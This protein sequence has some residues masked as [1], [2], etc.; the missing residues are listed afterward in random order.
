MRYVLGI[1]GG[2]TKTTGL[3]ADETGK[4]LAE[5]T[6]GAS[7]SNIV[8]PTELMNTFSKLKV[9]LEVKNRKAFAKV[10]RLYAGISGTGHPSAQQKIHDILGDVMPAGVSVTIDKDAIIALY[11]GPLG[12]QGIVTISIGEA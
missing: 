12:K 7:N 5:A 4:I 6:V 8:S 9:K 2:G 3:I 11:P 1:D 10:D